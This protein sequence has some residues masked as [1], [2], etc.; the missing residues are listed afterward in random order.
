MAPQ[1]SN[2]DVNLAPASSTQTNDD[3]VDKIENGYAGM[4][5]TPKVNSIV[6]VER[7]GLYRFAV[8]SVH[9]R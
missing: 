8:N 1:S 2:E 7:K 5:D 9:L 3:L 6:P 4:P